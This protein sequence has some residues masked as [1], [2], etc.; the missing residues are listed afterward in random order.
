MTD[1]E[2]DRA[3]YDIVKKKYDECQSRLDSVPK[4]NKN[5]RKALIIEREMYGLC[6]RA[7]MLVYTIGKR[8][9]VL[10]NRKRV[11]GDILRKYPKLNKVFTQLN[12]EEK[13]RFVASLQAEI[14]MRDQIVS[15][16]Y[17]EYESA[18]TSNDT[19][20]CLELR[21]KIGGCEN[22]F[23]AWETWRTENN[24]YSGMLLEGLV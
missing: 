3:M 16:Y 14:Y 18:K 19:K 17:A 6:N 5:E 21:I 23:K 13:K 22:V 9:G 2:I 24:V 1:L 10:A 11:I 15:S 8:E 4:D 7:G 20:N 12:E